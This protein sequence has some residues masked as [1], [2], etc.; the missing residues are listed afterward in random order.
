MSITASNYVSALTGG[1]WA[2][3]DEDWLDAN[4]AAAGDVRDGVPRWTGGPDGELL[5]LLIGE[6]N[7]VIVIEGET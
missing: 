2:V 6:P 1:F 3:P 4:V 5:R 7:I